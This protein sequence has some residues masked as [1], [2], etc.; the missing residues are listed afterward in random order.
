MYELRQEIGVDGVT[1]VCKIDERKRHRVTFSEERNVG[2]G[3]VM[4]LEQYRNDFVRLYVNLSRLNGINNIQPFIL[5]DT[6]KLRD[7]RP[8]I[9]AFLVKNGLSAFD[10]RIHKAEV[11]LTTALDTVSNSGKQEMKG[12]LD[13]MSC[14]MLQDGDRGT[15]YF[16]AEQRADGLCVKQNESLFLRCKRRYAIKVYDKG[17][18]Q[19][20]EAGKLI[21][22][23]L[24]ILQGKLMR[25]FPDNNSLD[26]VLSQSGV[27]TLTQCFA[28]I[29]L[30]EIIPSVCQYQKRLARNFVH[31][32]KQNGITESF[33]LLQNQGF[34]F[35]ESGLK[36]ALGKFYGKGHKANVFNIK[37]KLMQKYYVSKSVAPYFRSLKRACKNTLEQGAI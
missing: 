23:E 21:R 24:V 13:F 12:L 7:F 19:G 20:G 14:A 28:Q 16:T 30:D 8:R 25:L 11:N 32:A 27:I 1:F 10:L 34:I 18:E 37:N 22:F 15:G 17:R 6:A 2:G 9:E 26:G 36:Y 5:S 4:S 31:M 35:D 33:C 3:I 29:V